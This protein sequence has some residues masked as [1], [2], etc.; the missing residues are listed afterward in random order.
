MN[1]LDGLNKQLNGRGFAGRAVLEGSS[2]FGDLYKQL[3]AFTDDLQKWAEAPGASTDEIQKW[4]GK[5]AE[6]GASLWKHLG[7]DQTA[8]AL[9]AEVQS[10]RS[11]EDLGLDFDQRSAADPAKVAAVAEAIDRKAIACGLQADAWKASGIPA[12]LRDI[13]ASACA[14][15]LNMEA[16]AAPERLSDGVL[17]DRLFETHFGSTSA[18]GNKHLQDLQN[19]PGLITCCGKLLKA[20]KREMLMVK[21]AK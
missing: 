4:V 12:H 19:S 20:M 14:V 8:A 9:V 2:W 6:Q 18:V 11:P 10:K 17:D 21:A 15:K 1:V 5:L 13:Y 3:G 7:T 16:L